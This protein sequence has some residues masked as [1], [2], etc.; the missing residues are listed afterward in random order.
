MF[1]VILS[2]RL[3]STDFRAVDA[4]HL[5]MDIAEVEKAHHVVVFLTGQQMFPEGMGGAV[6][7]SWTNQAMQVIL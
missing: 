4:T 3:V 5:V 6:Y 1:G 7:F 2:G